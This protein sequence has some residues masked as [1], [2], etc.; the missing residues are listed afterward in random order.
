[1]GESVERHIP[2]LPLLPEHIC[3]GSQLLA[4]HPGAAAAA[5]AAASKAQVQTT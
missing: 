3:S 4:R 2:F 5:A 1:V